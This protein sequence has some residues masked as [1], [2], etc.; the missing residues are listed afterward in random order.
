VAGFEQK[1]PEFL[2]FIKGEAIRQVCR[3]LRP[4]SGEARVTYEVDVLIRG[5]RSELRRDLPLAAVEAAPC[6]EF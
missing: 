3:P 5:A 6:T 4:V 2:C 1:F